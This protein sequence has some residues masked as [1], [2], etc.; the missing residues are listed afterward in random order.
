MIGIYN[1]DPAGPNCH[2]NPQVCNNNGLDFRLDDP[3][4]LMVE[5]AYRYNEDR[6]AGTIKLGGWNHFG[7]FPRI[8][9]SPRGPLDN[10]YSIYAIIDQLIWRAPGDG[11][12]RAVALFGRIMGAPSD[13]NLVDFYAEGGITVSGMIPRRPND[14]FAFGIAY[15]GIDMDSG[16]SA[17]R[18]YQ[19]LVEF[20]YTTQLAPGWRLQPDLQ[21]LWQPGGNV[22]SEPES[23]AIKDAF[24]L[25]VRSSI[26]F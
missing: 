19:A 8:S 7:D 21:Y 6:L 1:G 3:P 4:L 24:V 2:G 13:R 14:S 18:T 9:G 25:G 12:A 20:C 5:G 15:T 11:D 23:V 16:S 17:E 26:N 10:N 22:P